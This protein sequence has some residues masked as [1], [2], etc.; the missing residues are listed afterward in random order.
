MEKIFLFLYPIREY[1][2]SLTKDDNSLVILNET[3]KKRYKDKGYKIICVQYPD[4]EIYGIDKKIINNVIY[5][6]ISFKEHVTKTKDGNYK[7]PN[8]KLILKE[9]INSSEI[10]IGGFHYGDCVKRVGEQALELGLNCIVDLDLTDLFFN[11]YNTEYFDQCNYNP[12]NFKEYM[13]NKMNRYN[14]ELTQRIFK[15]NYSSP[16]YGIYNNEIER[17][18]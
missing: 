4:K 2:N 12:Q 18:L 11:L 1:F 15:R 6:D 9:L 8:E 17:K 13:I 16:V 10:I 3:I 14:D 7:Y 5:T